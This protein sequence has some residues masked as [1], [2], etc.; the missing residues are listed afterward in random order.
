MFISHSIVLAGLKVERPTAVLP[1]R[2]LLVL[3]LMREKGKPRMYPFL[4]YLGVFLFFRSASPACLALTA[5]WYREDTRVALVEILRIRALK[6]EKQVARELRGCGCLACEP[7]WLE[8][9]GQCPWAGI[10]AR[11]RLG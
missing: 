8:A 11:M 10:N 6:L 4:E 3:T 7:A 2:T 1:N 9:G 5:N